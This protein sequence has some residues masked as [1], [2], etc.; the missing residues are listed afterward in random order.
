MTG[1]FKVKLT[2]IDDVKTF[3]TICS[4]VASHSVVRQDSYAV[5]GASLMGMFSLDL[6]KPLT[7]EIDDD[8]AAH[9]FRK[10][11]IVDDS[12]DLDKQ[13]PMNKD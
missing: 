4:A 2:T 11:M 6:S 7:V 10:W 8:R 9:Y 13:T 3:V 5:N 12:F 1:L